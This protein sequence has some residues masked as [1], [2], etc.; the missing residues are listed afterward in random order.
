MGELKDEKPTIILALT[1]FI[2]YTS[3]S[4]LTSYYNIYKVP[5]QTACK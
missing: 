5:L 1:L 2:I 4:L 3:I